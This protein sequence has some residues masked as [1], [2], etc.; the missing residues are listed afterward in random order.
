[1]NNYFDV[2][3]GVGLYFCPKTIALARILYELENVGSVRESCVYAPRPMAKASHCAGFRLL[4]DSRS[5]VRN[6][7]R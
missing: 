5:R 1:M 7:P 3:L 2:T 6:Q 4:D